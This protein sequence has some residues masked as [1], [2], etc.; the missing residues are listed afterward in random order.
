MQWFDFVACA[1]HSSERKVLQTDLDRPRT[2]AGRV[3]MAGVIRGGD[4]D[5]IEVG[6]EHLHPA[7][8]QSLTI[9]DALTVVGR[10]ILVVLSLRLVLHH[11]HS[12][13]SLPPHLYYTA[14]A[15]SSAVPE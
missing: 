12:L 14:V 3:S 13:Y 6:L 4:H 1:T 7:Q 5:V 11:H 9:V 15:S 2:H 10:A 8:Y